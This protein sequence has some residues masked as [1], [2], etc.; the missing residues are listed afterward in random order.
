MV[1]LWCHQL[2]G[3]SEPT[4]LSV[5]IRGWLGRTGHPSPDTWPLLLHG[6]Q[7][8]MTSPAGLT[9]IWPRSQ[10]D[11]ATA[12][13]LAFKSSDALCTSISI[14]HPLH[15]HG[16]TISWPLQGNLVF[17]KALPRFHFSSGS[18]TGL[19][20]INSLL[21]NAPMLWNS[22][23]FHSPKA[24]HTHQEASLRKFNLL[25]RFPW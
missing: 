17:W 12:A 8:T 21:N 14:Q 25:I 22:T 19:I 11:A 10:L 23:G 9:L 20:L 16:N 7:A 18:Y 3:Q 2:Y 1:S 24:K 15:C 13:T 5:L 4:S 6:N